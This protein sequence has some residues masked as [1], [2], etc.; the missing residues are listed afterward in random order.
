MNSTTETLIK[1]MRV[2]VQE[3]ESGD[4]VANAAIAEAADRLEQQERQLKT[5]IVSLAVNA[6]DDALK[7]IDLLRLAA[8]HGLELQTKVEQLRESNQKL[9]PLARRCLWGALVWND[10][11]FDQ[12]LHVYCRKSVSEA[13]IVNVDQANSFL[14]KAG[15][16]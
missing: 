11:N 9:I 14:D 12:P 4:G 8:G 5:L 13:G 2:L 6:Y 10:H 3:I 7:E 1:A 15:E 16:I